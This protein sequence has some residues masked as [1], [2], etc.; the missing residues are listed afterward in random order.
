MVKNKTKKSYRRKLSPRI[1]K[2]IKILQHDPNLT[3]EEAGKRAGFKGK[4]VA[5]TASH[6]LHRT[7]ARGIIIEEMDKFEKLGLPRLMAKLA[8][9]LDAEKTE[10][11]KGQAVADCIDYPT[12][13]SYLELAGRWRKL[14]TTEEEGEQRTM[15][16][17]TDAQLAKIAMGKATPADFIA[18]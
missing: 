15:V 5:Q 10:F 16:M 11:Y 8:E 18:E 7:K 6:S 13:K 14:E 9:G 12:R 2:L 3:L 4:F 17:L 1:T